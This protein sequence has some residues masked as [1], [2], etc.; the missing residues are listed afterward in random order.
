MSIKDFKDWYDKQEKICIYCGIKEENLKD[1][2]LQFGR[3]VGHLTLDRKNNNNGYM[4]ENIV[5]SCYRCNT[6]KSN[7]FT[8]LEMIE[9]GKIISKKREQA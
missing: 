3:R 5:L 2:P 8:Y 9:I 4:L 6:V 1:D 7:L